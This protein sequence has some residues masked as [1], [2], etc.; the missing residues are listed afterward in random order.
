M[1][2][3]SILLM[4]GLRLSES[5]NIIGTAIKC[6]QPLVS[7]FKVAADLAIGELSRLATATSSNLMEFSPSQEELY[8]LA[9]GYIKFSH[10]FRLDPRPVAGQINTDVLLTT[11]CR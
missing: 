1:Q 3:K 4:L 11:K 9:K 8:Q 6:L 5:T 2:E 7:Q 10:M